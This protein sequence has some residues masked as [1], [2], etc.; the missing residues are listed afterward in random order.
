[1]DG[2]YLDHAA[3]TPARPEVVE[4]MLP[5]LAEHPG[6]P[7]GSHA[8]ARSARRAIDDARDLVAALVGAQ[9]GEVVFT[10]GGTEA[11]NLAVD[12]VVRSTGCLPVCSAVEHPAVLA[13]VADAGG[14][15]VS[16][17]EGGRIDLG[18]LAE[19]L[20]SV[21]GI[22]LVSVMLANNETGVVNDL[23]SV[24]A[25]LAEAAPDAVLHTDAVQAVAWMDL[26]EACRSAGLVSL[27]GHK[28]GGPKGAGALVVRSG[29]PLAPVLRGG[30]QERERRSGTQNVPAIVGLGEAA[31]LVMADRSATLQRVGALRDRLEAGLLAAVSGSHTTVP[32]G[33]PRTPAVAHL[34]FDGIES[35]SLL[36][37]MERDGISASAGSSCASGA[38][39]PSHV[40]AAMGVGR[41]SALG[42]LRL[43][44][45]HASDDGDVD[46]ALAVIPSVVSRL[47]RHDP[48]GG[49][50]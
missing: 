42:S 28:F 3:S 44:L 15:V 40:L 6:N 22:G 41:G 14:I 16:T 38:Q 2:V 11:D 32:V 23:E 20:S 1:M 21:D 36:F 39:E 47:R 26:T 50:T 27:T 5:W 35:E 37:L 46:H 10:S 12:G 33:T 34:W 19:V 31:R 45:G 48:V 7:S 13:P 18:A 25:L 8:V 30:G 9:P 49:P 43:S 29:V 24:A 4:A 17:D